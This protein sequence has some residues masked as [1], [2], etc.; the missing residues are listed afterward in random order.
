MKIAIIVLSADGKFKN[1]VEGIRQTWGSI[2][3]VDVDIYYNY[4]WRWEPNVPRPPAYETHLYEDQII[5][6][7]DESIQNIHKKTLDCFDWLVKN[8]TYDYIFRCCCGSYIIQ[9]NL[10][11]FLK[12]KPRSNYYCG[13]LGE[14]KWGKFCS[15]AG[16]FL[17]WDLVMDMAKNKNKV[18]DVMIDDVNFGH[19]LTKY[20]HITP[21]SGYRWD[22]DQGTENI[23]CLMTSETSGW[24]P[25]D[26]L[27][28]NKESLGYHYHYHIRHDYTASCFYK[29]HNL[30]LEN[31]TC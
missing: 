28:P 29:L 8:K 25:P 12:D 21:I 18:P 5:S 16:Y 27:N 17:S 14:T 7:Y 2:K 11:K 19:Y 22:Y 15:G 23:N 1:L 20:K 3:N 26:G 10:I 9:E 30:Y 4:A 13:M 24:D 6:G 31:K